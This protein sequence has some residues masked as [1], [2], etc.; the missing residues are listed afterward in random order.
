[1]AWYSRRMWV[2]GM[3]SV[4][5]ALLGGTIVWNTLRQHPELTEL[6]S[7][8]EATRSVDSE[9]GTR[10]PNA[11]ES[12]AGSAPVDVP[13]GAAAPIDA[14]PA[15]P[16]AAAP[17]SAGAAAASRA[18]DDARMQSRASGA[19]QAYEDKARQEQ[20]AKEARGREQD[21][22][23]VVSNAAPQMAPPSN[24]AA[25]VDSIVA[26]DIG[27]L[28]DQNVAGALQRVPGVNI[29]S[30]PAPAEPL[31][32]PS[33]KERLEETVVTGWRGSLRQSIEIK[34]D[35]IGVVDSAG[36]A[37]LPPPVPVEGRDQFEHFELNS[38]KRP[39]IEAERVSTFSADVDTSSYSFARKQL[40]QGVLP[41]KDAVRIEEMVNY[42]D[43]S[44]PTA[45]SRE[46]PFRP[47]VVVSDSPWGRGRKLIHI[48]IK[49]YELPAKARPDA[50][51][52]ML[53]DVSG[54]M[55][56]PDK[57][58][59]VKQSMK[60]LLGSLKPSDTVA[61]VVYAG[62]AGTVLPPTRV[63]EKEAIFDALDRLEAGGSTAGAEGIE[64]AYQL[65]E[66]SFRKGAV[67]RVIL[68]T[69]GD[70]NVGIDST[71]ELKGYVERKREK[72]IFLSVLGFGQGNYRDE[73]AQAL[74]QNGN[75]VA[76]YIDTLNEARKVLVQEAGASLVTIAKDVKL[77]V[78]FNPATV[79]EY[80]LVGYETRALERE[81]FNNDK[82]DAGDIGAGHSVTAIYEITPVGSDARMI[83]P[84]RYSDPPPTAARAK[85]NEYG[86]LRIRYKLPDEDTSKLIE[87]P[88]ERDTG[89]VPVSIQR[90][91]QFS[92]AVAGFAQLLRGGQYTGSLDYD[93]VIKQALAARG[94]DPFGYRNEFVQLVRKARTAK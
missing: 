19:Q 45:A 57:L 2:G 8:R 46:Q 89:R 85:G 79:A 53:L 33:K 14:I 10:V 24:D 27:Q 91:V 70:F 12:A 83:E 7:R 81:D 37:A 47:T 50:N 64:L 44:W 40:E 87:Q 34:R 6:D 3:A 39:A 11:P 92:T 74:A 88:I 13:P 59:L 69:D 63:G 66:K 9:T 51:L 41:Q 72:G 31:A 49:G 4:C 43:Y 80:R 42:F 62:A 15:G 84:G 65:A 67:N 5:V 61:I 23:D 94:D 93:D 76:A 21:A 60:M 29:Q 30:S 56:E 71:Q 28:A 18:R 54:S 77:Q 48:G 55:D 16:N 75:G 82:V 20:L 78:E 36:A 22:R 38:I 26:E 90:D 32:S 86:F 17:A 52:V 68:C 1:M 58:P 25:V 73:L 35:A